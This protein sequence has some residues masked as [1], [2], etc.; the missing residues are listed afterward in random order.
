MKRFL[1]SDGCRR[2]SRSACWPDAMITTI[3]SSTTQ[4][5]KIGN[6]SA[7]RGRPPE[8][9]DLLLTVNGNGAGG[10]FSKPPPRFSGTDEKLATDLCGWFD[11]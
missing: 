2:F 10:Q 5:R 7:D 11:P 6:Y 3:Q 9:A 1:D 8:M 4:V